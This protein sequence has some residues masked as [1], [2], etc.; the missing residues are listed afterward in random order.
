MIAVE[1]VISPSDTDDP[2]KR[3]ASPTPNK[4]KASPAPKK[5]KTSPAPKKRKA[6]PAPNDIPKKKKKKSDK[7]KTEENKVHKGDTRSHHTVRKCPVCKK[8]QKKSAVAFTSTR[9]TE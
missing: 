4:R 7:N 5:R 6:S 8:E 3:K 1:A 2:E 9:Q